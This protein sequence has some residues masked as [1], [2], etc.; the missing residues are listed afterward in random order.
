[1]FFEPKRGI[2]IRNGEVIGGGWVGLA[3]GRSANLVLL[4]HG[5]DDLYG[6]WIICEIKIMGLIRPASLIGQFGITRD[7]VEPFGLKAE[8]FYDHIQ[9]AAGAAHIFNYSFS[10]DAVGYFAAL[11]HEALK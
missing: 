2:K 11:I 1:V 8:H 4:K 6:H 10:D 9:H 3:K 7:T 5:A